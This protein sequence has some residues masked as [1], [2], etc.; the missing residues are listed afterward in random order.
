MVGATTE[1]RSEGTVLYNTIIALE[2][3]FRVSCVGLVCV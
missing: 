1:D 3:R 2:I